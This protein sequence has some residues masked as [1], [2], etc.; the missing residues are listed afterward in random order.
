MAKTELVVEGKK[1]MGKK[2]ELRLSMKQPTRALPRLMI[3]DLQDEIYSR[4]HGR[5]N[6]SNQQ[7]R[8]WNFDGE[9]DEED[10]RED[11]LIYSDINKLIGKEQTTWIRTTMN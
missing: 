1:D 5:N 10:K 11:L 4:L 2:W 8:W 9:A 6:L 3:E 7:D